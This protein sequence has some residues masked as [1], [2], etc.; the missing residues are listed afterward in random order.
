[1]IDRFRVVEIY[2][3]MFLFRLEFSSDTRFSVNQNDMEGEKNNAN[4]IYS[5]IVPSAPSPT[6]A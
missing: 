5:V 6:P 4:S 1:M 2:T 3:Y